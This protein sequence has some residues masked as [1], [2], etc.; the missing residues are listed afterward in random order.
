M[1]FCLLEPTASESCHL[2][3]EPAGGSTLHPKL[4]YSYTA[5]FES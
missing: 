2:L 4:R 3:L 1:L 5:F